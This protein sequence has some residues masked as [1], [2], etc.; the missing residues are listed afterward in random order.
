VASPQ[1]RDA[2]APS[3]PKACRGDVRL[4]EETFEGSTVNVQLAHAHLARVSAHTAHVIVRRSALIRRCREDSVVLFFGLVGE[5]FFYHC[6]GVRTLRPGQLVACD[7]DQPFMR[8]CAT[9][10]KELFLKIP[11]D[12][13][14]EWT[15][16]E[17]LGAP[18]F[19]GFGPDQNPLARSLAGLIGAA[20]RED[21]PWRPD[22]D[23]LLSMVGALLGGRQ[24]AELDPSAYL[25]AAHTYIEGRLGDHNLSA[26]STAG[27][28]GI[29]PR[30]SVPGV[31]KRGNDRPTIC[32]QSAT[33]CGTSNAARAGGRFDDGRGG[34]RALRLRFGHQFLDVLF[35]PIRRESVR[36]SSTRGIRA[37]NLLTNGRRL[38][39]GSS[40]RTSLRE[41]VATAVFHRGRTSKLRHSI[42]MGARPSA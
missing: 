28:V 3:L 42:I 11:R 19:I 33:G 30:A 31:R 37:R 29:S 40:I 10:Y 32:A 13:F 21:H 2:D 24:Y 23:A 9:E 17:G 26:T 35:C 38:A 6:D 22:E 16:L 14:L 25:A 20:V 4:A 18:L 39:R 1:F 7:C 15:G 36:R 5:A 12:V 41:S 8:G 34:R 27:A